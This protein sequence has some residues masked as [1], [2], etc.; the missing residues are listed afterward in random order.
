MRAPREYR[1][2]PNFCP[3][4]RCRVSTIFESTLKQSPTWL[5]Y[6]LLSS[7]KNDTEPTK[8]YMLQTCEAVIS[9]FQGIPDAACIMLKK[10]MKLIKVCIKA[11]PDKIKMTA[12]WTRFLEERKGL[13]WDLQIASTPEC[14]MGFYAR[15]QFLPSHYMVTWEEA[16]YTGFFEYQSNIFGPLV[17]DY[18]L[19]YV[20]YQ[21]MEMKNPLHDTLESAEKERKIRQ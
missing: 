19:R 9:Q 16:F 13:C 14:I 4:Q 3:V 20:A 1:I 7:S 6:P 2:N 12:P 8:A 21:A 18:G 10:F 11:F 17:Q 15:I 5:N